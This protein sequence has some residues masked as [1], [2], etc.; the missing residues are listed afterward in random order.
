M[1][2]GG[3]YIQFDIRD[4]RN[5]GKPKAKIIDIISRRIHE[6]YNDIT[7]KDGLA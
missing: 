7:L 1:S 6:R 5:Q 4:L 3:V 2:Y